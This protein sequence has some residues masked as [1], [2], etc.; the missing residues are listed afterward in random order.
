[1]S[2]VRISAWDC[3]AC[4]K[5]IEESPPITFS[6]QGVSAELYKTWT[7]R[8]CDDCGNAMKPQESSDDSDEY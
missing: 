8:K 6:S 4:K 7:S 5:H 1:M 3:P 2:M